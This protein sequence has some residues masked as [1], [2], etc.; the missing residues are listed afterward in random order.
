MPPLTIRRNRYR[1]ALMVILSVLM[2]VGFLHI[3]KRP[4]TY[5]F[6]LAFEMFGL[7]FFGLMGIGWLCQLKRPAVL[8]LTSEGF[9]DYSTT[10]ATGSLI[11]WAHV[12]HI[13]LEPVKV[14]FLTACWNISITLADENDFI[15]MQTPWKR[16]LLRPGYW[17]GYSAINIPLI[18]AALPRQE[19]AQAMQHYHHTYH[20]TQNRLNT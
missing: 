8:I 20:T 14:H 18:D 5:T 2:T 13:R 1:T 17:L 4:H 6:T 15:R 19:I 3:L 10:L 11:P 9:Y 16:L 7:L 12:Q